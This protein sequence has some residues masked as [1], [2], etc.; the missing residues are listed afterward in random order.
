MA[1]NGKLSVIAEKINDSVPSTHEL[2]E[3]GRIDDIIMLAKEQADQ[4]GRYI[5]VNIGLKEPRLMEELVKRIQSMVSVPLSIDTPSYEIAELALKAYDPRKANGEKPLLNSISLSRPEMFD[6]LKIQPFKVILMSNER[7]MDGKP[8]RNRVAVDVLEGARQMHEIAK[9]HG[10]E[11]DD[12]I[13]DPSIAPIASD[14][15]GLT[16]MTVE[17]IALIGREPKFKGC[18]ISVGLSNFTHMLPS[19]TKSG[20]MVKTP[21]ENAFLTLTVPNGLDYCVGNTKK[22]YEFLPDDHPALKTLRTAL[23]LEGV[24]VVSCVRKFYNS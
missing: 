12:I 7:I 3:Q 9:R 8:A 23:T 17:G 6:L 5:D 21:L 22:K 20:A 11:N 24:G 18:H 14:T 1:L 10:I 15:Q 16:K 4:G 13:L 2:F 19:K